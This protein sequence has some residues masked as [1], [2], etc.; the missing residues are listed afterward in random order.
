[1]KLMSDMGINFFSEKLK[2]L[3][4][5]SKDSAAGV[6]IRPPSK[7]WASRVNH[8]VREVHNEKVY[9]DK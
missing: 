5:K 9:K 4:P 8:K 1:M 2:R 6:L 7:Q 3:L